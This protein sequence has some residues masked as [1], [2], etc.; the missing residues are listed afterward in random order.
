MRVRIYYR[1]VYLCLLSSLFFATPSAQVRIKE[2]IVIQPNTT[3]RNTSAVSNIR[4]VFR[5][6]FAEAF[7]RLMRSEERRVGKECRL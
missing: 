5:T 1:I 7:V 4:F 6:S 2:K 3:F